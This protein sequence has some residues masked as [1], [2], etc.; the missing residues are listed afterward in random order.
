M[1]DVSD[2]LSITLKLGGQMYPATIDRQD[3]ELYREAEKLINQRLNYYANTYG[4]L[5]T[6]M[7]LTMVALEIAVALKRTE[8]MSN[9]G[10]IA[11]I[12]RGLVNDVDASLGEK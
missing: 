3:E 6:S 2:K 10:P 5:G 1:A 12:L 11:D 8:R 4:N 9:L 7:Y